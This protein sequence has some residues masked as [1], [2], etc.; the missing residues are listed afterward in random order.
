[1][2]CKYLLCLFDGLSHGKKDAIKQN[3]RHHNIVKELV[4]R[5][6]YTHAPCLIPRLEQEQAVRPRKPVNI[7]FLKALRYHTKCL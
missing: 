5:N 3:C 7:V 1:M 4:G 2:L 6:I